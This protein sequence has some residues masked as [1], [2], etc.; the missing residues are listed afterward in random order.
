MSRKYLCCDERRRAAVLE[1]GTLNGIDF[2]E[3]RDEP[4]DLPGI[5]QRVLRLHFLKPLPPGALGPENI[6]ID[7]GE[8]IRNVTA[9]EVEQEGSSSPPSSPPGG[10]SP[11]VALIL[12]SAAGDFSTYTLRIVDAAGGNRPPGWLDPVLSAIDFSFKVACDSGFDCAGERVCPPTVPQAPEINYLAKDYESFRRL[13]LDRM[14]QLVPGW[15]ERSPADPGVALVELLAYIGDRLSYEQDARHTEAY[16]ATARKRVS[17]RRLARLVDYFLHDGA[18]ARVWA[19]AAVR[20]GIAGVPLRREFAGFRTKFT[21]RAAGAG[22]T[23]RAGTRQYED[24]LAAGPV[25]FELMEDIALH[26]EHNEIEFYDWGDQECCLPRGAVKATLRGRFPALRKGMVL[27]LGEKRGPQT[28]LEADADPT[29]RHAVRLT[30]VEAGEDPLG[31]RFNDPP[32]DDA[33]P[34]TEIEWSAADALPFPL[35]ISSRPGGTLVRNV[36]VAWGNIV[37]ADH[38]GTIGQP[39]LLPRVP[40]PALTAAAGARADHCSHPEAEAL[41]VRYRPSLQQGPVTQA[42]P[43]DPAAPPASAAETLRTDPGAARPQIRLIDTER[44]LTWEAR[45]DLLSSGAGAREFVVEIESGGEARLRFGDD[46]FGARP[47]SYT[48]F[49]AVYRTG[50]G[51]EGNIGAEALVHIA[52]ADPA[53]STELGEGAVIQRVWNPLPAAGGTAPETAEQARRN[54]PEAFRTQQRAVTEQDYADKAMQEGEDIQR[55]AATFRW[56]GSWY[57]SFVTVDR[58]GGREVDADFEAALRARLERFRMAGHDL[59]VD[60]PRL[61]P[62]EIELK[63]CLLPGYFASDVRR[64]FLEVFSSRVL[65]GGGRGVFHPDNFT[66]GQPVFLSPLYKAAQEIDGVASVTATVFQR[67]GKPATSG[68]VSGRLDMQR[69]EIAQLE[70]DPN[71]PE[72]GVFRVSLQEATA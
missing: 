44:N 67:Q 66:F 34:V 7:G 65:P 29:R 55:A 54:A 20:D 51:P 5:R 14:A 17:V 28:G 22:V 1:H 30:R 25:I 4:Q 56:T 27:V 60:A 6:R 71:F 3:V 12:T 38:G 42:A 10:S 58:S 43:Y 61:A 36:S 32:S 35:C 24:L 68:L 23:V 8:R 18:N 62:L 48:Q 13:L 46:T 49:E 47:A 40:E 2:L 33:V 21:S 52:S 41:P 19:Q 72:R 11:N 69:L 50:N 9:V 45:I 16:L 39:E 63:V 31:G 57:T 15:T 64:E 53:V 70:N 59:E 26:T 37:L